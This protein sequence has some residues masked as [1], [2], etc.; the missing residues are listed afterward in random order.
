MHPFNPASLDSSVH[1]RGRVGR[2]FL[3]VPFQ[4]HQVVERV[5]AVQLAGMNEANERSPTQRF[6]HSNNT[7]LQKP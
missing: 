7:E 2:Q 3:G 1:P 4:V 5:H 6:R